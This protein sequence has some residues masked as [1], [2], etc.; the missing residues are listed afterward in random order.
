VVNIQADEPLLTGSM[1]D[2]VIHGLWNSKAPM[3][4]LAR[5]MNILEGFL[6]PN[7]VKVVCDEEGYAL[8][9]SRAPIPYLRDKNEGGKSSSD[10]RWL[11]HIG[12][13]GYRKDFLLKL[14][15]TKPTVLESTERLE[16]LRVL[17]TGERI[18]VMCVQVDSIGV[19]TPRD[20]EEVK[21][22]L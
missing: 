20:L 13:Y 8:Y 10:V 9:F 14:A 17:E 11:K 12:L 16:Q 3:S 19:D 4:T 7:T 5:P 21:K 15:K 18:K 1:V 2:Q 6:E 22:Y